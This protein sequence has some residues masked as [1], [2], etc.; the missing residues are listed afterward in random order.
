MIVMRK[1]AIVIGILFLVS[2]GISAQRTG[3]LDHPNGVASGLNL[4]ASP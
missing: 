1:A 4:W 3:F 2:Q